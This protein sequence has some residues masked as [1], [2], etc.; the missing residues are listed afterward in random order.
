MPAGVVAQQ[1]DHFAR[2]GRR[3]AERHQHPAI[4]RQQF[5]GVPVWRGDHGFAGAECVS[6]RARRDLRLIEVRRDV[7]VR[8]ADELLEILQLDELV[9]EDDVLVDF[10]FLGENLEAEPV[11]FTV[12]PQLRWDGWRRGRYRRLRETPPESPAKR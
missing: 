1:A 5:R 8:R 7:E 2:D 9:V 10:V 4:V 11:G 3:V 6:Q 12:L